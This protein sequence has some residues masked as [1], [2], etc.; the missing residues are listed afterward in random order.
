MIDPLIS[1]ITPSVAI[2]I[3]LSGVPRGSSPLAGLF[4]GGG[5]K[6]EKKYLGNPAPPARSTQM[7]YS[8]LSPTRARDALKPE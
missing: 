8:K 4:A 6:E 3:N 5:K 2:N 1:I 7:Y